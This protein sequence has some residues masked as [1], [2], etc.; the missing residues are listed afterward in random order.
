MT[1]EIPHKKM[2]LKKEWALIR[3]V[4][5]YGSHCSVQVIPLTDRVVGGTWGT[6]KLR[7]SSGLFWRR[8]LWAVLAQ[9]GMSTLWW[10]PSSISSAAHPPTCPEGWFWR[11]C[12]GLWHARTMK[13]PSLDSCQKRLQWAHKEVDL[14]PHRIVDLVLKVEHA[15]KFP[16]ALNFES[17]DSSFRIVKQGPCFTAIEKDSGDN[18]VS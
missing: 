12:R 2:V 15:E 16:R 10:C 7:S 14:A 17:L 13:V 6:I 9:A 18:L 3:A 5:D 1:E 11:G 4:F 8:P